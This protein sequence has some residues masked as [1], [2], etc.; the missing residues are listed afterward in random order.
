MTTLHKVTFE[1]N[2]LVNYTPN[3]QA[4]CDTV[5]SE[6]QRDAAVM[7]L[8]GAPPPYDLVI[9][10]RETALVL[11][12]SG[13]ELQIH[14][15]PLRRILADY[16]LMIGAHGSALRHQATY[17]RAEAIDMGRRA[18]HNEAA[19]MLLRELSP[20]LTADLGTARLLFT[21]IFM[22]TQRR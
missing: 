5:A 15:S 12:F 16:E 18:M 21:L 3:V 6:I 1:T 2:A 4:D 13:K 7:L 11:N 9:S 22:L 17:S 10:L 19:E 14:F 8:D 20:Q